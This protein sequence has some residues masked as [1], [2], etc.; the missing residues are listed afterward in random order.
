MPRITTLAGTPARPL[1]LAARPRQDRRC[2]R[3]ALEHGVNYF[4]CYGP[5]DTAFLGELR[6][7]L[8]RK[9]DAVLVASGSGARTQRSLVACRRKITAALGTDELD[10]F[11][12]EYVYPTENMDPVFGAGGVLDELQQWK[13]EGQIRYVGATTH[14]RT[15]A[16]QLA[17]DPRVDVLM[18]RFNM[19]HR[20]AVSEVFPA[21][22]RTRTPII[23]FTATR[24]G[25]LLTA[26]SAWTEPPPSA[27]D[28]YRFCLAQRAVKHVLTAPQTLAE[29]QQNLEVLHAKPMGTREYRRWE[30]YGD[31]IAGVNR[32]AFET[33]WP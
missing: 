16:R 15:L 2:V 29:L 18:H 28:C 24:W 11:F 7:V 31:L 20:K 12:A 3:Y 4:F 26:P 25:T 33:R 8:R 19:A 32:D 27:P 1:G 17:E 30:A 6:R 21:A 10:L 14:D 23:A 5:G 22:R 9:R 13:R